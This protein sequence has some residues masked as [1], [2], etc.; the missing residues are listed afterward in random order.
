M[1]PK[2][3][4]FRGNVEMKKILLNAFL[5]AGTIMLSSC[6]GADKPEVVSINP[7]LTADE[8][9]NAP[10][11]SALSANEVE[12]LNKL[13]FH[14]I[15]ITKDFANVDDLSADD[16]MDF[17][18]HTIYSGDFEFVEDG[19]CA[20]ES[21]E[22][23][24]ASAFGR[25]F[26]N[27]ANTSHWG[28]QYKNGIYEFI[29]ADGDAIPKPNIFDVKSDSNGY[30]VR[31]NIIT[32][33]NGEEF[34]GNASAVVKKAADSIFGFNILS[35]KHDLPLPSFTTVQASS[36]LAP[37]GTNNY[38]AFNVL[39]GNKNT[40]WIEGANGSGIGE[41][42]QLSAN[43]LQNVTG[44]SL[45]NGYVKDK[46]S[47]EKNS[48]PKRI[49][50]EFSDGISFEKTL[51]DEDWYDEYGKQIITF[52]KEISTAYVKITILD[53]YKGT[54]Y[55]DTCISEIKLF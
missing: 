46:D 49:K 33:H 26:T 42:I 37:Q 52:D 51:A 24:T 14:V 3:P 21:I 15:S 19:K 47:Y 7:D 2:I 5:I 54:H 22:K 55:D 6:I 12:N 30:I 28:L 8:E 29:G 36:T 31:F 13:L 40:A 48:R 9:S 43:S 25:A 32:G 4:K 10:T 20:T 35:L 41:W 38:D 18:W 34:A 44:I 39:D 27:H 17:S 53:V 50:I 11:D 16:Y 1:R 23:I 45:L